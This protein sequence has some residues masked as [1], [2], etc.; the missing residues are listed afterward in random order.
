M[1]FTSVKIQS[2]DN[3]FFA[4]ETDAEIPIPGIGRSQIKNPANGGL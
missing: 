1:R 3:A 2:V 4:V